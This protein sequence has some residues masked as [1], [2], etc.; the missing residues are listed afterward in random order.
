MRTCAKAGRGRERA[1]PRRA[2]QARACGL[3]SACGRSSAAVE[4]T[5]EHT[6]Q[7]PEVIRAAGARAKK[8]IDTPQAPRRG[9][10]LY[11]A[12]TASEDNCEGARAQWRHIAWGRRA[13]WSVGAG[14]VVD[15]TC[16]MKPRRGGRYAPPPIQI[17]RGVPHATRRSEKGRHSDEAEAGPRLAPPTREHGEER[18]PG[19]HRERHTSPRRRA[20]AAGGPPRC[21]PGPGRAG[22]QAPRRAWQCV[23]RPA[24][25][26]VFRRPQAHLLNARRPSSNKS[27]VLARHAVPHPSGLG[28]GGQG[29]RGR[30]AR[31]W[32]GTLRRRVRAPGARRPGSP[33]R[34]EARGL[35]Q[36]AA[37]HASRRPQAAEG[38]PPAR[39]RS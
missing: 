16:N 13:S 29:V 23:M 18:R 39:R 4:A 26:P 6:G 36:N 30:A 8:V 9:S 25:P 32:D 15:I 31:K 14:R 1:R 3:A 20:M 19:V 37:P 10:V 11:T 22:R 17:S 38:A 34:A 28:D 5:A 33:R 24:G 21:G 12:Q 27:S 35:R 2:P 7:M